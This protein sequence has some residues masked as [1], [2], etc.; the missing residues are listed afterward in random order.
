MSEAITTEQEN[1]RKAML[2]PCE[3]KEDLH[4]WIRVYLGLDLP[5]CIVDA[6]STTSPM[7]AIWTIYDAFRTRKYNL[8]EKKQYA[9]LKE[10]MDY[11]SRDSF[12]T[13]GAAV[14]EVVVMLHHSL[15]VAHMAAIERQAKKS[16][17]YVRDFMSK[18]FIREFVTVQ[19][20]TRVEITRF[21]H[22]ETKID[23]TPDEFAGLTVSEQQH[24]D[25][26]WNYISIV[27][28][29]MAGANSE[30]VPFMV[31]DEVDV[32]SNP[33]AYEEAKLIPSPW[34]GV[35][36]ITLYIST[37][38]FAFG[39]VQEELDKAHETGLLSYHWNIID[40]TEACPPERHLPAEPKI[41]IFFQEPQ[42][43]TK[44]RAISEEEWKNLPQEKQIL[45]HKTEG[46]AGC[47][48]NCKLFFACKGRL[49]THQ[50]SKSDLL[51]EIDHT[52]G[53]FR[54]VTPGM[55]NA[56]L[57]CKKPS[58][59]GLI[60][61]HFEREVHV[62][63]AAQMAAKITGDDY[64]ETFTKAQLI[65]LFKE[66]G[67]EFGAGM[68]HGH[69]HN[70]A[71]VSGV[72][73]GN[74]AFIFDVQ[75]QAELELDHKIDLL[76][77]TIKKWN[78]KIW[79]D[80]SAPSDNKTIKRKGYH[81]QDWQKLAD[82]VVG[83]IQIVRMKLYPAFGDP[84]LYF[85]ADDEGVELLVRRLAKYHWLIDAAGRITDQPDE[86]VSKDEGDDE[87]DALRYLIMNWFAPRGKVTAS[88]ED[89]ASIL[90][91]EAPTPLPTVQ[92]YLSHYI[93]EALGQVNSPLD[94]PVVMSGAKGRSGKFFWDMT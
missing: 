2:V 22:R 94:Q 74:R 48:K 64:P 79:P 71:T 83:G 6:D 26:K 10:V 76:D 52:I 86:R 54:K 44:G 57:L 41:P 73:D 30:H 5:D 59:E 67:L 45:Y 13:L 81:V 12:K 69:A 51:K 75:S 24:Y 37:R 31:V 27:I 23:L 77:R 88:K 8:P 56:Q 4:D 33:K 3:S 63:S 43:Q 17:Q 46:F 68:D 15:S 80:T 87:C 65:E 49:A 78:P 20:E 39:L 91:A 90:A 9:D 14:L 34:Q 85:L 42:G 84:Q 28:C 29:T 1:L 36:P 18:D 93:N 40:V 21:T 47:L 92:N 82:S 25:R 19:N 66:R 32:V 55:A 89:S 72:K 62:I 53:L 11:A 38:K 70:F 35:S 16:Q 60:Y 61:P 50:K 58:E 7:D